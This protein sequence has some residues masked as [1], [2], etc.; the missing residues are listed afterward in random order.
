L[1]KDRNFVG[2][3]IAKLVLGKQVTEKKAR[4]GIGEEAY[5]KIVKWDI[6][7]S[8]YGRFSI[9]VAMEGGKEK[10]KR[11]FERVPALKSPPQ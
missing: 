5:K 4:K 10:G 11:R 8:L 6:L 2:V 9:G 3:R 7:Q 1:I